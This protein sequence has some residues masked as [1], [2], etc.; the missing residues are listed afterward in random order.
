MFAVLHPRGCGNS[1]PLPAG[2]GQGRAINTMARSTISKH[3]RK[4]MTDA[5]RMLWER[6]RRKQMKGYKFRRQCAIG[7]YVVDF[8]CLEKGLVI[9]VDG[10][11]HAV[12]REG[13]G[14]AARGWPR[15]ATRFF[16][17][18]ITKCCVKLKRCWKPYRVTFCSLLD[19]PPPTPPVGRGAVPVPCSEWWDEVVN[20][21]CHRLGEAH[22]G[23]LRRSLHQPL[24]A[25][26]SRHML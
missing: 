17:F 16:A 1:F 14:H 26:H 15:T 25:V 5:E 12:Q 20:R 9:E 10:G 24:T 6:L 8:V 13:M 18:G 4:N 2:G 11:Q 23:G 22:A 19:R 7:R 21:P 3:L